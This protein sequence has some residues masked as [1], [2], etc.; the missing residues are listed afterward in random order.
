MKTNS[1]SAIETQKS[2]FLFSY[3]QKTSYGVT[4]QTFSLPQPFD[5]LL[6]TGAAY[7]ILAIGEDKVKTQDNVI[8]T[9]DFDRESKDKCSYKVVRVILGEEEN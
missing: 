8:E 5:M 3:P 7:E 2:T 4:D 1:L 9:V 6:K